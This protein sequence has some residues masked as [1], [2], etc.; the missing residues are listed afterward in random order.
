MDLFALARPVLR[1]FLLA[2][3]LAMLY[4]RLKR[5][6]PNASANAWKVFA[7]LAAIIAMR[8]YAIAE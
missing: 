4:R 6:D 1:A 3:P 8:L 7:A 2:A 5:G